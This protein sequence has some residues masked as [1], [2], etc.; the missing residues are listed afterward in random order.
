MDF[1]P[2][3]VC[4]THCEAF[5]RQLDDIKAEN[6]RREL[7][8]KEMSAQIRDTLIEIKFLREDVNVNTEKVSAIEKRPSKF[9]DKFM[10]AAIGAVASGLVSIIMSAIVN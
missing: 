9:M 6:I 1:V 3:E 2:S 8:T 4:K 7:E 10:Y 5:E